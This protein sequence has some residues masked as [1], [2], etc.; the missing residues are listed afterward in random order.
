MEFDTI[1]EYF[2][3]KEKK[4]LDEVFRN[5][6]IK[7][8]PVETVLF[9]LYD[10]YNYEPNQNDIELRKKRFMQDT[11]RD[12]LIKRYKNCIITGRSHKI[13]EA[14]H[15]KPYSEAEY[16]EKY[17]INNGLL[18]CRDLHKLF[19][20]YQVSINIELKQFEL[21]KNILEDEGY[22]DYWK[23]HKKKVNI[24]NKTMVYLKE[25]YEQF[26]KG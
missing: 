12:N 15:I 11:F 9:I 16:K 24:D 4:E 10:L 19:D 17:D 1:Y 20:D 5:Y 13:C 14:C 26:K 25:H 6:N 21:C 8:C 3:G 2:E 7:D 23:Y 22:E 18:L